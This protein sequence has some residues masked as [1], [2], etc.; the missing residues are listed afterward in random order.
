MTNVGTARDLAIGKQ[1]KIYTNEKES[2]MKGLNEQL[3][4]KLGR[5]S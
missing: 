3:S 1:K 2:E 5:Q 4:W